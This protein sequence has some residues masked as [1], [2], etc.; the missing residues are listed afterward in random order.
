VDGDSL[1]P[2]SS[3]FLLT[4]WNAESENQSISA[5]EK[6]II[7]YNFI[8]LLIFLVKFDYSSYSKII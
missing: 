6:Y 2:S 8:S 1:V 4:K 3:R 5:E 7:I